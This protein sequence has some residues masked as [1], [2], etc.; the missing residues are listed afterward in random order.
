MGG[1]GGGG[2]EE[3]GIQSKMLHDMLLCAR[4]YFH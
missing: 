4:F 1:E 3:R 2:K